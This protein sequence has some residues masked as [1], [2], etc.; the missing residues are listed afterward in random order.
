MARGGERKKL[1][2]PGNLPKGKTH[3]RPH[4]PTRGI[5][6][7]LP[8]AFSFFSFFLLCCIPSVLLNS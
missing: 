2:S 4:V 3:A 5:F 6:F 8:R 7:V 1:D